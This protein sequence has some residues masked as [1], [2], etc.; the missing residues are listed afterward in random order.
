MAQFPYT[1][2][3]TWLHS[4]LS[5]DS[6]VTGIVG[7]RIHED[8]TPSIDEKG[9][10]LPSAFPCIV[11]NVQA[12]QPDYSEV[13]GIVIW[14]GLLYTV[15]GV[16]ET[17]SYGGNVDILAARI[18]EL[19]HRKSGAVTG[20]RVVACVRTQP[21]KQREFTNQRHYRQLGGIYELKVQVD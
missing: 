11:Y 12:T 18:H 17:R 6:I 10:P 5:G 13:G 3:E 14:S 8:V 1:V 19:L 20:G 16:F 4:T 7:T 9:D 15:R 2:A 21:F